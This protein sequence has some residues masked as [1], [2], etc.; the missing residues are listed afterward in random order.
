MRQLNDFWEILVSSSCS[1]VYEMRDGLALCL[2]I[3]ELVGKSL[4]VVRHDIKVM[5]SV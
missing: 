3:Y 1:S 4:S 2:T 5:H